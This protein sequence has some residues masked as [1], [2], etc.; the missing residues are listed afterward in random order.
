MVSARKLP[1]LAAFVETTGCREPAG[2]ALTNETHNVF[3]C[4]GLW[5]QR[6]CDP[7][8]LPWS[9]LW[10]SH[11]ACSRYR[12]AGGLRLIGLQV[13]NIVARRVG[14]FRAG[15]CSL[16][17]HE[18]GWGGGVVG[19]WAASGARWGLEARA[20]GT[21]CTHCTWPR[22]DCACQGGSLRQHQVIEALVRD[23]VSVALGM[24][25]SWD[26]KEG[27][28]CR[29]LSLRPAPAPH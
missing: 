23:V 12:G 16:S 24:S 28:S 14:V 10:A 21:S 9:L 29:I 7:S 5:V 3:R 27:C 6:L 8:P 11:V 17:F 20:Q 25:R 15:R 2:L 1:E 26:S 4:R 18:A 19:G 13:K 22:E